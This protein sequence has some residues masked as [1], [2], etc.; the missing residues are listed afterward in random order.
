MTD[1]TCNRQFSPQG[2]VYTCEGSGNHSVHYFVMGSPLGPDGKP[3]EGSVQHLRIY[4]S[5]PPEW[6]DDD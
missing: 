2:V 6:R 3:T 4:W 1:E 5:D